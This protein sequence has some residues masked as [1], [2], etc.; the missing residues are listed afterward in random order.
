VDYEIR[1]LNFGAVT[2]DESMRLRGI[3]P[4][5]IIDVPAQGF[6]LLGG[7][8]P[9]LVDAGY[10]DTSVLGAG[11]HVAPGQGFAEQLAR[12][13]VS[14][15]DLACVIMT[16]LHRD[17]AG[18]LDKV[19]MSVPVVVNRSELGS[20]C[21]GIQ[22]R[23]YA[24]D[25]LHHLLDRVYTPGAM[26]FL[27]LEYS[28]PQEVLPGIVCQLS[29]GHTPGSIGVIV[30]TA[31]GEAYLCGDL[32]YDVAGAL[33]RQPQQSFTAGVQPAA[34]GACEPALSNNFTPS[35]L[36]EIGAVKRALKYRFI[37]PAHDD[38]GVLENGKY[39][40]RIEGEVVPGPV[41][42]VETISSAW[43]R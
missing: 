25:D 32:F 31:E 5:N 38:P 35:V 37:V 41:T 28:G 16:H 20:A 15:G 34:L 11:G 1:R 24:R 2:I 14:P 6:L 26:Q 10:R 12:H 29:G 33:R 30:P 23:A 22:G 42:E 13:G 40:G 39:I 18:H 43:S 21:T 19:P 9:V 27:D 36:E 4:G 3:V 8:A 7:D 17:H